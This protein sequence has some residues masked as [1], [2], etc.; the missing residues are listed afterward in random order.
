MTQEPASRDGD[1]TFVNGEYRFKLGAQWFYR[2]NK[3]PSWFYVCSRADGSCQGGISERV[4][5]RLWPLLN[6]TAETIAGLKAMGQAMVN[7]ITVS[8]IRTRDTDAG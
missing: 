1:E 2:G 7:T 3:S 5:K 6:D 8:A 4:P